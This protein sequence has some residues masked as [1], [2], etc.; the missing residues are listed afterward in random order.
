MVDMGGM[1]KNCVSLTELKINDLET[2]SLVFA[3]S[4]FH[5]CE[6]LTR[7]D[8]SGMNMPNALY[9]NNM[10]NDCLFLEELHLPTI[11]SVVNMSRMFE[12]TGACG[13]YPTTI[14]GTINTQRCEDM[15]Y[16]FAGSRVANYDIANE[17]NTENLKNAEGMFF[18]AL[19]EEIDLSEWNTEKLEN[20]KKMFASASHMEV[21]NMSGWN[22]QSLKTC[23]SMFFACSNIEELTLGW[24]NA[25]N[26]QNAAYLFK[27]C[28]TLGVLDVTCFN[29]AYF[30]DAREMFA[31]CDH[32]TTIYADKLSADVS[33]RMFKYSSNLVGA[34]AYSEDLIDG[35]MAN[36]DGYF[37]MR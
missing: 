22:M 3:E 23:E 13:I 28:F 21:C 27:R 26:I 16:M 25:T 37:T 24:D 33:D 36:T 17:F 32:L 19:V 2:D 20:T 4:M 29:G 30:G 18:D 7:L 15:S 9:C 10:F 12:D 8:M 31:E 11:D 6:S 1:F 35:R 5:G 34:V 14:H